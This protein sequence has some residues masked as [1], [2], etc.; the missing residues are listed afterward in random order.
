MGIRKDA[1]EEAV[2]LFP[3]VLSGR[4]ENVTRESL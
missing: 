1:D 3:E 4:E 2:L